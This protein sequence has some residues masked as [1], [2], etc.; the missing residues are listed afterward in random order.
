[1]Q[2]QFGHWLLQEVI[3]END[4]QRLYRAQRE[5]N[6]C[7]LRIQESRADGMHL[8]ERWHQLSR[9]LEAEPCRCVLRPRQITVQEPWLILEYEDF[10]GVTLGQLLATHTLALEEKLQLSLQLVQALADL[11]QRCCV[12]LNLTPD[13]V[14][15][16][17]GAPAIH[18]FDLALAQTPVTEAG[19]VDRVADLRQLAYIAP[20]QTGRTSIGLDY[21]SDFY[22][23]GVLLYRLFTNSLPFESDDPNNLIYQHLATLPRPPSSI[24]RYLPPVLNHIILKLLAKSP[25]DRYQT[26]EGLR[27]DLTRCL[28]ALEQQNAIPDFAIAQFDASGIFSLSPK[29][30]C[31]ETELALLLQYFS[32]AVSGGFELVLVGGYSGIGKSRIIKELGKPIR[33]RNGFFV[34]GKFDQFKR[35]LPYSAMGE[36]L[37]GLTHSVL[38][39]P[40][41]GFSLWQQKLRHALG[42]NGPYIATLLPELELIVGPQPELPTL[43]TL[44]SEA[45]V[46][47][48]FISFLKC[49]ATESHPLV[50][51]LDD[52]Q[53]ADTASLKLIESLALDSTDRHLMLIGAYR[54]NEVDGAHPLT[55]LKHS[56]L[57][58]GRPARDISL[59]P[60]DEACVS[61]FIADSLRLAV[62]EVAALACTLYQKTQGN[63]F[64]LSRYLTQLHEDGII[65]YQ[66]EQNRWCWDDERIRSLSLADNVV[67]LLSRKLR[68]YPAGT[69]RL[70]MLASLLGTRFRLE[71][72]ALVAGLDLPVCLEGLQ[73]V[74]AEG[75]LSALDDHHKQP[76]KLHKLASAQF[77]FPHDRIQQAAYEIACAEY[78]NIAALKLEIGRALLALERRKQSREPLFDIVEHINCGRALV[79]D[80]DERLDYA[81]LNLALGLQAK[82]ASAYQPAWQCLLAARDFLGEDLA[83]QETALAIDIHRELAEC[84]YL[85]G[86]FPLADAQYPLLAELAVQPIDRI[87][88]LSVQ[89]NQY[90]LQG[91][92]HDALRVINAGIALAGIRFPATAAEMTDQI[93][94]EYSQLVEQFSRLTPQELHARPDMTQPL[95]VAAME[96]L[97]VQWYASYLVGDVQLNSLIAVTIARL[98]LEKGFCDVSAFGFVTSALVASGLQSDPGL[99]NVLGEFGIELA[100]SRDN[101]F[102]RGTAYLLYTTFT[103]HWHHPVQSS[104]KYFR[105]AWECSVE[106]SDYV[107]AGYVINVR[108]SDRLIAGRPLAELEALYRQ[109]LEYLRKVKQKDMEDATVAGG[110]QPVLALMGKTSGPFSF[111]DSQFSE[112]R[113]LS[114]YRETG[115]HQAYFYQARIRHAFILQTP[116]LAEMADKYRLVEQFVPG[117]CKV[118]EANFYGALIHLQLANGNDEH[119]ATAQ[120]IRAKFMHWQIWCKA[121][122]LHKRLLLDAEIA[123]VTGHDN[124]AHL[125][126]EQ[127]IDEA[128]IAGFIQCAA[129]ASE[130][131]AR[132]LQDRGMGKSAGFYINRAWQGYAQWGANAKLD[133]LA[134]QWQQVRFERRGSLTTGRDGQSLDVQALFKAATLISREVKRPDLTDTLLQLLKEYSG[135]TYGALIHVEG[136]RLSLLAHTNGRNGRTV[137]YAPDE[138]DLM[139]EEVQQAVP[140][141]IVSYVH[142]TRTTRLMNNPSEW[143]DWGASVYFNQRRP[144]SII[145]HP[146]AGQSG[147]IAILYLENDLTTHAFNSAKMQA[148]SLIAQQAAIA[149]EN[150]ALYEQMESRIQQRTRELAEAKQRAEVATEAKS[151]FLAKMSHEIRTPMNA[152][153][154]LSRLALKTP[155]DGEQRDY[156]SKIL[157]SAEQLL[158]LINDILD[159]SRIEAGKLTIE[160]VPFGLETLIRQAVNLNALKASVKGLELVIDIDHSIPRQLRGD[161]LRLQ[162]IL[163]N[164]ISNAVKFTYQGSVQVKVL[165][166]NQSGRKLMLQCS[167]ID[168]G[169]GMSEEQQ[170]RLFESFTQADDSVTR[171]Y[172]GS[173]VGLAI[174]KQLCELMGGRIWLESEPGKGTRFHFTIVLDKLEDPADAESSQRSALASLKALV[175]DDSP[176]VRTVLLDMLDNLGIKADQADNGSDALAMVQRADSRGL[177]YDF[178]LMDWRMPGMDGLEAARRIRQNNPTATTPI[179]MMSAHDREMLKSGSGDMGALPFIEKPIS[180]STLLDAINLVLNPGGRPA[181]LPTDISLNAAPDLSDCR[182]LLVEDNGINRQVALGF[183]KDTGASVDVAENGR[184]ALEKLQQDRYDL[185]L[186][187]VQMPEM[188]GLTA[189]REIRLRLGLR[190]LPVVAMTAHAMDAD[191][192][193][194]RKAGMDGHLCKPLD[195]GLLYRTLLQY[196]Q[197]GGSRVGPPLPVETSLPAG[198]TSLLHRLALVKGLDARQAVRRLG[199]KAALYEALIQ[200]FHHEQQA[201]SNRLRQLFQD[202]EREVLSRM[203]HSLR[204]SAAY[205][206]AYNLSRRCAVLESALDQGGGRESQLEALI[207]EL[208][209]LLLQLQPLLTP[210][211][212]M[213]PAALPDGDLAHILIRLLPLL[214][215]SDFAAETL[216]PTLQQ[217]GAGTGHAEAVA[218]IAQNIRD[219]EYENAAAIAAEVLAELGGQ[220]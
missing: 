144:L 215:Q 218:R 157:E 107:S 59:A 151:S 169:I 89:A 209:S 11:H 77:K 202:G 152:V 149:I 71:A 156:V 80:R 42:S 84:A 114:T 173:G 105:I 76:D 74:L 90:Q 179:F 63:P 134:R 17:P 56:L 171:R 99:A 97:R 5:H 95:L 133:Q 189:T 68:L 128:E 79:T 163:V 72:L 28:A 216:I 130:R 111:D 118:S 199:D 6:H 177:A 141:G 32:R 7:L 49:F 14:L 73:P 155:L 33:D 21:R 193:K 120:E 31:R 29:L 164:L 170:S 166:R 187:D 127:A 82:K 57:E 205:I 136:A 184:I 94:Q 2:T 101:R 211:A 4:H 112:Q 12:L 207:A 175:V 16:A 139:Q 165:C 167:V 178:I 180:Q 58:Q 22:S 117:Q 66:R 108:S 75:L 41:Q 3:A 40:D 85:D 88:Y 43:S 208:D 83:L 214:R 109:E 45:R 195:P 145:C 148:V 129:V 126:Y 176:L 51:F 65:F 131:Y 135:A 24:A 96:L 186:M 30:Y 78:P 182:L 18:F 206:G 25:E 87:R 20:E 161:P 183:L 147:I 116:D 103:R 153:I 124:E 13:T 168:T 46:K 154:G 62:P 27:V 9:W 113:F 212:T 219:I 81:R 69:C 104:E 181:G 159:F 38:S 86:E 121:N 64:F 192:E 217:R 210:S 200:D 138:A 70:L 106:A 53:W 125:L 61:Q 204:S 213:V 196:L 52:L 190:Q 198:A 140:T 91:R 8:A 37:S 123:R 162:Q 143:D 55:R 39:L 158:G 67:E 93:T 26:H 23:L 185:V 115:L 203:V 150:A 50:V 146:I 201:A 132:F 34:E 100:D 36:A 102:I 122:F 98:S 197:P 194:S 19:T 160:N 174:C 48:A 60:L 35:D 110:L 15:V 191:M 1:M 10:A 92:F 119:L 137:L 220:G 188:D 172:G 54:D 142:K 47:A 44:E